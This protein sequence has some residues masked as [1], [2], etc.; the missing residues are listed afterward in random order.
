MRLWWVRRT[1]SQ[2][3]CWDRSSVPEEHSLLPLGDV[4]P[5]GDTLVA[6][7]HVAAAASR[8]PSSPS[9]LPLQSMS[10]EPL[11][12][13]EAV[14]ESQANQAGQGEDRGCGAAAETPG[15]Q[16]GWSLWVGGMMTS[17]PLAVPAL[18]RFASQKTACTEAR[19]CPGFCCPQGVPLLSSVVSCPTALPS[20]LTISHSPIF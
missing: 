3:C 13:P 18:V 1:I 6:G 2:R 17:K 4:A 9:R 5:T 7:D 10:H 12:C 14:L 20:P 16:S 19:T 8:L 11:L 15:E